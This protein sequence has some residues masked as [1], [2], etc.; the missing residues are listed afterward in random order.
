MISASIEM[1]QPQ[2][3]VWWWLSLNVFSGV[4]LSGSAFQASEEPALSEVEG[5]PRTH[6][7]VYARS[8][9]RLNC[10]GFRDDAPQ[11]EGGTVAGRQT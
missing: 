3:G 9:T 1:R 4:I 6:A 8:L 11:E 7:F 2:A 10:A 5:I